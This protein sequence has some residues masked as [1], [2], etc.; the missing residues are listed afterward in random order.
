MKIIL[1]NSFEFK[2]YFKNLYH[3]PSTNFIKQAKTIK[4]VVTFLVR[5][6]LLKWQI[7]LSFYFIYEQTQCC[8]SAIAVSFDNNIIIFKVM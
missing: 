8:N 2:K 3:L 7:K 4:Q 1:I 5:Q 6:Q